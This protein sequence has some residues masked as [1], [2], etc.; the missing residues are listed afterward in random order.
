MY[1]HDGRVCLGGRLHSM[2]EQTRMRATARS[3]ASCAGA[4]AS[5]L[6][7]A[8]VKHMQK[9]GL[10]GDMQPMEPSKL[11]VLE[12]RATERLAA[13]LKDAG[14]RPPVWHASW[15]LWGPFGAACA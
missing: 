1:T 12:L 2:H 3:V 4:C 11:K 10:G 14:E 6:P 15:A 7:F 9:P 5:A 8:H 13:A